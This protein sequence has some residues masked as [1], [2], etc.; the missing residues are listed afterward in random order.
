MPA[1]ST[2][3]TSKVCEPSDRPVYLKV[4]LLS[5]EENPKLAVVLLTVSEGPESI[6]VSG[7]VVSAAV[8][9]VQL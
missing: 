3:L 5:L 4:T 9:K 8:V 1:E 6:V 2:A 7:A